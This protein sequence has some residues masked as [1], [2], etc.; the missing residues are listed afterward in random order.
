MVAVATGTDTEGTMEAW[1]L[2]LGGFFVLL[3][4]V[5][6]LDYWGDER[7]TF[8]GRPIE[9]DW[10]RQGIPEAAVDAPHEDSHSH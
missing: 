5:L 7:L 8:R 3:P 10:R 9:R 1:Q 2:I 4:V 6:M